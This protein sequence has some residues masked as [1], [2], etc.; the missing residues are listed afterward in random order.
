MTQRRA[1]ALLITL[2]GGGCG[3]EGLC[4]GTGGVIDECKEGFSQDECAE[5][6]D[7]GVNGSTWTFARGSCENQ[8]FTVSCGPGD[9]VTPADADICD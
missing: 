2:V 7:L 1:I 5:W 9:W 3:G 4:I 8:G 6:D